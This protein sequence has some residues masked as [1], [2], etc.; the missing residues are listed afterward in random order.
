MYFEGQAI[1]GGRGS[2]GLDVAASQC[3]ADAPV[4]A[5]G[6]KRLGAFRQGLGAGLDV[7]GRL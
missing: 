2:H 4:H 3:A 7:G 1:R 5:L 6:R